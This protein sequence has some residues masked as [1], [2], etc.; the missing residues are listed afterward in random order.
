[1]VGG[2]RPP[3]P[4]ILGQA[5][6]IRKKLPIFSLVAPKQLYLVQKVQLTLIGSPQTLSNESKVTWYVVPK[7]PKRGLTNAKRPFSV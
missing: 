2:E 6:T 7:S 4:T 5:D 3:L 1:M